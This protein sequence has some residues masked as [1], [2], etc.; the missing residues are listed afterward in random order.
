MNLYEFQQCI[1]YYLTN[2]GW[3]FFFTNRS[4]APYEGLYLDWLS[5][6]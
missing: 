2:D 3:L 6:S 1:S 4:S 5:Q